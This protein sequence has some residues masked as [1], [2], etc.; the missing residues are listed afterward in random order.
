MI[1]TKYHNFYITT[2][3]FNQETFDENKKY[4][5][6]KLKHAKH[7]ESKHDITFEGCIYGSPRTFP[8]SIPKQAYIIVLEMLNIS[9]NTSQVQEQHID[10]PGKIMGIGFI[11]NEKLQ[12]ERH[13]IYKNFSYNRYIY[14]GGMRIDRED[15]QDRKTLK[16]LENILFCSK[17]HLKRGRGFTCIP[18]ERFKHKIHPKTLLTFFNNELTNHFQIQRK[19]TNR[20]IHTNKT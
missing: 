13:Y 15:I 16:L 5:K 20:R 17:S 7:D 12:G 1:R 18:K 19:T 9:K 6:H 2:T 8:K 4:R 3:R 11:K 14:K 10:Y